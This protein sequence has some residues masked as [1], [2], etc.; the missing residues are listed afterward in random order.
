MSDFERELVKA[1]NELLGNRGIAYRLKQHKYATQIMDI[2]V[3]SPL[4]EFYCGI[5]CKSVSQEKG[6][7]ALYFS[8]HFTT[9][10]NGSHQIERITD[11]LRRSGRIGFLAVEIRKGSGKSRTTFLIPWKEVERRFN[12]EESGLPLREIEKYPE[13]RREGKKYVIEEVVW[14]KAIELAERNDVIEHH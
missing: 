6:T 1:L 3:D 7:N 13:L 8:Q 2:L 9:T 10:R 14:R 11:F 5:E 12:S 4:R